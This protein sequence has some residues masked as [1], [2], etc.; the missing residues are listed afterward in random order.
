[1]QKKIFIF[2]FIFL[3]I[4]LNSTDRSAMASAATET[5]QDNECDATIPT[6]VAGAPFTFDGTG[7]CFQHPQQSS[8]GVYYAYTPQY[9]GNNR[10]TPY[11][12]ARVTPGQT[13]AIDV[14]GICRYI[15]VNGGSDF[16][17][18][19]AT[20]EE[21]NAFVTNVET[22]TLNATNNVKLI[23]CARPRTIYNIQ[24]GLNPL[25]KQT[26]SVTLPYA[27]ANQTEGN[28][29]TLNCKPDPT[30][31]ITDPVT[32]IKKCGTLTETVYLFFKSGD[33]DKG[34]PSVMMGS[35][36]YPLNPDVTTPPQ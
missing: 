27:P 22:S 24:V 33:S 26:I 35:P 4:G 19:L 3:L 13:G 17:I 8:I 12:A 29:L 1:M 34:T 16:F 7:T 21:W 10:P 30:T 2:V 23:N 25:C 14:W 36:Q 20:R 18:P 9:D 11:I 31:C 5:L 32:N 6:P 28:A 15:Q